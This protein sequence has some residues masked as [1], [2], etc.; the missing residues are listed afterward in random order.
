MT[1]QLKEGYSQTT[2][3]TLEAAI[4]R[5]AASLE[6][7][8]LYEEARMRA[9]RELSI[10]RVTTAISAST[11]YEQILQTTVREIGNLLSDTEVAI[12]ILDETAGVKRLERREQ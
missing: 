4:E 6:S 8:R 2:V 3:P 5:L 10:S 11:E 7:A 12:Q 1:V 9:D